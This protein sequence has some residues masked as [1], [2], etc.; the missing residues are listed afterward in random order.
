MP[1]IFY[2]S[3]VYPEH[4]LIEE[5]ENSKDSSILE[6]AYS[7][8]LT[9]EWFSSYEKYEYNSSYYYKPITRYIWNPENM[10]FEKKTI[11]K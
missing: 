9:D 8:N 5:Y 2:M 7:N 10:S 11:P 3:V 6:D 4:H 1:F